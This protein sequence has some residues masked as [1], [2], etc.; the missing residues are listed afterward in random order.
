MTPPR[1]PSESDAGGDVLDG[2][3][4]R[5]AGD[6]AQVRDVRA[7][8]EPAALEAFRRAFAMRDGDPLLAPGAWRRRYFEN[9][10][11]T[12]AVAA[13]DADGA[14]LAQYAG[15]PRGARVDD[16]RATITQGV[17]SLS[18]PER[19]RALGSLFARVGRRFAASYGGRLG[20]G[21]PFMWGYPV[22]AAWRVGKAL[23]G[24][25]TLRS[26][27]ALVAIVERPRADEAQFEVAECRDAAALP[28]DFEAWFETFRA[29]FGA[30]LDRDRETLAWRYGAS[31]TTFAVLRR[32]GEIRGFVAGLAADF[33]GARRFVITEW[34]VEP[35]AREAAVAWAA[36][37]ANA[38]DVRELYTWLPPWCEDFA[39]LQDVGFRVR[40]T[41]RV[42]VGRSY[43]RRRPAE[44]YADRWYTT[45][46]DTDLLA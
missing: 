24:Y 12:R 10:A 34:F 43:D 30:T 8:D 27:V 25:E 2:G 40:P 31:D 15:L 32:A 11:G 46:G 38:A 22:R 42:M 14:M 35:D 6:A 4:D 28:G 26:Q 29:R 37:R 5:A 18:D 20:E 44:W 13:F 17:D 45:L 9:P 36:G 1:S 7:D 3:R 33:E 41:T 21:D 19:G 23:L 16:E 39:A